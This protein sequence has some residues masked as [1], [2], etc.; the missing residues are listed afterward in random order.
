MDIHRACLYGVALALFCHMMAADTNPSE[1]TVLALVPA[2]SNLAG[3]V[4]GEMLHGYCEK[5][6]VSDVQV[7]NSF[8]D[9]YA[10]LAQS[11]TH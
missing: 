9:L 10:K 3:T 2:I 11:E 8:I 4:M 1:I 7:G 5:D 6:F